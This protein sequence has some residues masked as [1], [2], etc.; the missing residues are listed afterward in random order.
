MTLDLER[1]RAA[2]ASANPSTKLRTGPAEPPVKRY[3]FYRIW[4][5]EKF[6]LFCRAVGTPNRSNAALFTEAD[7]R[8][9][10]QGEGLEREEVGE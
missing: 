3:H 9:W 5:D 10:A 6:Y 7:W 1:I 8:E 4:R 2:V